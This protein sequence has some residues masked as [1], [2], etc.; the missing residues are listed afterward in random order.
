MRGQVVG[1]DRHPVEGARIT[2]TSVSGGV[3]RSAR[4]D[5]N[6]R[7]TVSG[8]VNRSARTDRNGRYTVTFPGGDGDYFVTVAAVGFGQRRFEVKRVADED[9]LVADA[10]LQRAAAQLDTAKVV[11]SRDR[12][13]RRD[14]NAPDLSGTERP[15]DNT[16]VD[17]SQQGDLA[18]MA[19]TLPGVTPVPGADGDPNG[20]S[21]LGL[22]TDQNQTTLNG[23][24]SG[25]S[26]LPRDAGVMASLVTSPYDVS[27]GGFSGGR[28]NIRTRPGT[29]YV[30]R[31]ASLYG[32]APQLQWSDRTARALGQESTV[33]SFGGALSG[34]LAYDKAFYAV[35]YQLGRTENALRTLL[36][37]D[38]AALQATG[39]AADSVARLASVLSGLHVPTA[40]AGV[41]DRR[42][43]D[44]G[45]VFGAFDLT[46]PS[47][48]SGQAF[49][50]TV[51]GQWGRQTPAS[52]LLG[53]FPAHAGDRTNWG[54]GVQG[55]HSGYIHNLFLSET[56]VGGFVQRS[57]GTPY[58]DLPSGSVLVASTFA[59]GTGG[60][61]PVLFGGSAS[62]PTSQRTSSVGAM[63]QLSWFSAN[64][65]HRLKLSTELRRD[66]YAQDQTTNRFGTFGYNSLADLE[67][68][69]PALFTRQLAPRLR[70]GSETVGALSLGD[71]YRR[72]RSLQLQ[73]GV[74]LDANHFGGAPAENADVARAFGVPNTT[75]PGRLYVSPRAGFSWAYGTAPQISGFE[76]AVRGPRAVVRGGVGLF[77]NVPQATLLGNA[78]ANTGLPSA[79]QQL[80]CVGPATPVPDWATYAADPARVPDRCADGSTGSASAGGFASA[81]PDVTLFAPD[82]RA[83]RSLRS[84]L[85]WAGPVLGNRFAATFEGTYSRNTRQPGF[86]DLN[87]SG[88]PRFA[89]ADEGG[90][91]VYVDPASVVPATGAV[92][93]QGARVSPRFA[94][95]AEQRSDLRSE[96]RQLQAR[97]SP[98]SFNPNFGWSL[99]YVYTDVREQ[100]RGFTSTA[101]DPR[102]VDWARGAFD[103]RHQIQYTLSYNVFDAV[104]V[105][106]FGNV[107]SGLPFTPQ[108]NADVNGDG[109]ANDRAFVFDPAR[110][111]DP[112]LAAGM[113]S[114]VDGGS[115]EAR[116]CLA[117]QLG[118]L[119][120][121]NSCA[122]PWSHT[123][124]LSFR[125]NPLKVRLPQRANL[126]F[127]LS[128]P[129]GAVDRALHGDAGLRGW[130]QTAYPDPALLY[131]RGF[132]PQGP[133]GP[134][135]RYAVNPRFGA[136]SPQ[137]SAFRQPAVLTAQLS[138]DLG[139][140]RER[141]TLVQGLDRGRRRAGQRMPEFLLKGTYGSGGIPNPMAQLLRE[142]DT[143]QLTG[144]QAD[145]IATMNRWYVVRLDSIW[146]PVAKDFA[147]LPATY[148]H[149]AAYDRYRE[150][151]R[152]SV[153]LLVRLVPAVH[154]VLTAEQRRRLPPSIASALDLRY[155]AAVRSG[156]AGVAGAGGFIGM[157]GGG[158]MIMT[159]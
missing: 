1:P 87:F 131:V 135:F 43:S 39:L 8:G 84:N 14:A 133:N 44:Q 132:D 121:R 52:T 60:V 128:N 143:L 81:A 77:Q 66:G 26:S 3:N 76:G 145:S 46:P 92:A 123:A 127:T 73:Y 41:G 40:A 24:L 85:Q 141:Q 93:W 116:A 118:A 120:G 25:A 80:T 51:N 159:R 48:N 156:T 71:S 119:A 88:A 115:S 61:R 144:P 97:I 126:S 9:F 75:A 74:R 150:A 90:R 99:A 70:G 63:N 149:N 78:I 101:G 106:W 72:T 45:S 27:T 15:V 34:P 20:F 111:A 147:A 36:D 42:L 148:S 59:D 64:N 50:A 10:T 37:P 33:G 95:V 56:T 22:P 136:T 140:A 83:P 29:N 134:R 96:T 13:G 53:E 7:Y 17:P 152:A 55:R 82:W 117:R 154:G 6:G 130:G 28:Q 18:A 2:V 57:S 16:N 114:L 31:A 62:L 124:F 79:V 94:R 65:K 122:G 38:P 11:A 30:V 129:L 98:T 21:V 47:S 104:R 67:A 107:R 138:L 102:A 113:R 125:F 137:L 146:S 110:T 158:A 86:V 142:A 151:R 5:R 109:S 58:L 54:G 91:P 49:N 108:V 4:T 103:T 35:S 12:V 153:D 68:G 89:L 139:P 112:A 100:T 32:T 19:A 157:A 69:T 105:F 155:L 23:M